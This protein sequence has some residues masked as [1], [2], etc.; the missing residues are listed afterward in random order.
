MRKREF[1]RGLVG[2]SLLLTLAVALTVCGAQQR[3][4]APSI[5]SKRVALVIGNNDYK[6]VPRLMRAVNDAQSVAAT[7]QRIGFATRLVTDATQ[8]QMNKAINEFAGDIAG[9]GVG[10]MFFA[11]H[12]MQINSQNF[13]L[14]VDIDEPQSDS[15]V[16]DQAVSL[17]GIQSSWHRS[18]QSLL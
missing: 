2:R 11:G 1:G 17:Q 3:N 7:L 16:E 5:D 9:G 6:S 18:M 10:V 13:L 8:K 4:L 15:D 12:G 14:P